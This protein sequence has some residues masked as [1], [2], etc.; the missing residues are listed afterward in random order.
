MYIQTQVKILHCCPESRSC[1]RESGKCRQS[2][3]FPLMSF[4]ASQQMRLVRICSKWFCSVLICSKL[5]AMSLSSR[6]LFL[7][8]IL[9]KWRFLLKVQPSLNAEKNHNIAS[10]IFSRKWAKVAENSN[11]IQHWLQIQRTQGN[12]VKPSYSSMSVPHLTS[13]NVS[14]LLVCM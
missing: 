9:K 7:P 14:Q 13:P 6:T 10:P 11:I 3:F 2:C 4:C 8:K 1:Q 5:I 12:S